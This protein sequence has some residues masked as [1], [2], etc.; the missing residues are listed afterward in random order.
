MQT[1]LQNYYMKGILTTRLDS[2]NQRLEEMPPAPSIISEDA[3][4]SWLMD[5]PKVQTTPEFTPASTL[6]A[7]SNDFTSNF[8]LFGQPIVNYQRDTEF[9]AIKENN[10][11]INDL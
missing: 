3:D 7:Q 4:F 11:Q 6:I 5:I 8:N 1:K 9:A 10:E 2:I